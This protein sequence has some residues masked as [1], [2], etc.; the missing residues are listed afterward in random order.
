MLF[1]SWDCDYLDFQSGGDGGDLIKDLEIS[2]SSDDEEVVPPERKCQPPESQNGVRLP[3]QTVPPNSSPPMKDLTH[4]SDSS[5]SDSEESSSASESEMSDDEAKPASPKPPDMN[6]NLNNFMPP[7]LDIP[8]GLPSDTPTFEKSASTRS[9]SNSTNKINVCDSGS[10][11]QLSRTGADQVHNDSEDMEVDDFDSVSGFVNNN[12]DQDDIKTLITSHTKD[13]LNDSKCIPKHSE[14]NSKFLESPSLSRSPRI[15]SPSQPHSSRALSSSANKRSSVSPRGRSSAT[16]SHSLSAASNTHSRE[17]KGL[18][19]RVVKANTDDKKGLIPEPKPDRPKSKTDLKGQINKPQQKN[20][21]HEVDSK[22]KDK[23]AVAKDVGGNDLSVNKD[24]SKSKRFSSPASKRPRT[25]PGPPP[26]TP[27]RTSGP[28]ASATSTKTLARQ[29]SDSSKLPAAPVTVSSSSSKSSKSSSS[30]TKSSSSASS[31]LKSHTKSSEK[32]DVSSAT[33]KSSHGKRSSKSSLK[34]KSKAIISDASD[35]DSD[36]GVGCS[37]AQP[38]V[39]RSKTPNQSL[40]DKNNKETVKPQ[41]ASASLSLPGITEPLENAGLGTVLT[42]KSSNSRSSSSS[43]KSKDSSSTKSSSKGVS[44]SS[45]KNSLSKSGNVASLAEEM[46]FNTAPLSPLSKDDFKEKLKVKEEPPVMKSK[47]TNL[48][49]LEGYPSL[50][51]TLDKSLLE[52]V[53]SYPSVQSRLTSESLPSKK[54]EPSSK[55]RKIERSDS[56]STLKSE[57][58]PKFVTSAIDKD[59]GVPVTSNSAGDNKISKRPLPDADAPKS[60]AKRIKLSSKEKSSDENVAQSSLK[61]KSASIER[62]PDYVK[63]KKEEFQIDVKKSPADRLSQSPAE[64][65][66]KKAK[67][68]SSSDKNLP[69][70]K[71]RKRSSSTSSSTTS[72]KDKNSR[73]SETKVSNRSLDFDRGKKSGYESADRKKDNPCENQAVVAVVVNGA[74]NLTSP[75][76]SKE[77]KQRNRNAP[78]GSEEKNSKG[79]GFSSSAS[80]SSKYSMLNDTQKVTTPE[81]I[82]RTTNHDRLPT[83]GENSTTKSSLTSNS[84]DCDTDLQRINDI[85][86]PRQDRINGRPLEDFYLNIAKNLKHEADKE[87]NVSV[88]GSKYLLSVLYF[89]LSALTME[90][91][92]RS[93]TQSYQLFHQ[94]L[95]LATCIPG[96]IKP[97]GSTN[98]SSSFENKVVILCLMCQSLL[99]LKCFNMKKDEVVEN[100]KTIVEY[101]KSTGIKNATNP[102]TSPG[103]GQS[104]SSCAPTTLWNNKAN[105]APSPMSPLPSP[106]GSVASVESQ[107]SGYSSS[108]IGQQQQQQQQSQCRSSSANSNS[109]VIVPMHVHSV[110]HRQ[111]NYYHLLETGIAN[112]EQ[113]SLLISRWGQQAFFNRIT[114]RCGVIDIHS[115]LKHLVKYVMLCLQV[116]GV[117]VN[118]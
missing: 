108:E 87:P 13:P 96:V 37:P 28:P 29:N 15:S 62:I 21:V 118:R 63:F 2:D 43:R 7:Q 82:E 58:N 19:N 32:K 33:P 91:N 64:F 94:S 49:Y 109:T 98:A 11:Q 81:G 67:G 24:D 104:S 84:T 5:S 59:S 47:F 83:T 25:P 36:A 46:S 79:S 41:N 93:C 117:N 65:R 69:L 110:V 35:S 45:K 99:N 106:S 57:N 31:S 105:G 30:T 115:A 12:C 97:N 16:T 76:I 38:P 95:E 75:G 102:L 17:S 40:G 9:V 42:A 48:T 88:K 85:I 22:T 10:R 78:D 116:L 8:F 54:I 103:Q 74:T 68:S 18:A 107:S 26:P 34:I 70:H 6:W 114:E 51:V 77:S 44:K 61:V 73:E 53:P 4:T 50:M 113:S 80:Q 52:R 71:E 14:A 112:W 27:P 56:P 89:A 3:D 66:E 55:R 111:L 86:E 20:H 90:R 1:Y 101:Q 23:F 39:P 72:K 92:Q 60:E 100:R